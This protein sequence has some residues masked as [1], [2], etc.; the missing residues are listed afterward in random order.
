M[1]I[2]LSEG[3]K[4]TLKR[5]YEAHQEKNK[6]W[7]G[8]GFMLQDEQMLLDKL[9]SDEGA[10]LDLRRLRLFLEWLPQGGAVNNEE[11]ALLAKLY[12]VFEDEYYRLNERIISVFDDAVELEK[13]LP[14]FLDIP[15]EKHGEGA[16][17]MMKNTFETGKKVR[18][19]S[20]KYKDMIRE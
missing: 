7:G 4:Q 12:S 10:E 13:I 11:K 1:Y 20:L 15:K 6:H 2:Q 5:L 19:S 18:Y 3:E 17:E 16:F 9:S 14:L 8:N